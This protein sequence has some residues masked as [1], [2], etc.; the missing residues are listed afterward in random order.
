MASRGSVH[1]IQQGGFDMVQKTFHF[2]DLDELQSIIMEI[3]RDEDYIHASG[4]LFQLYNPRLDIEEKRMVSMLT[5]AFSNACL[6][7]ITSGNIAGEKLD[8][9][10]LPVELS[11]TCFRETTLIQYDLNMAKTTPFEAG[12]YMNHILEVLSDLKCLQV[13]YAS[14]SNS[15]CT[16][17]REIRHHYV[18]KFGVKAGRSILKKNTAHVYGT[19][20]YDS[21][22]VV[23]A[24]VSKALKIYMD[25]NLGWTPIGIDMTIT[26]T[27]GD[28]V[29][30]EIDKRPATEIYSKYLKVEP[31]EYFVQNVCEFPLI[32]K[33]NQVR[34]ARVPVACD[35]DGA[36][37]FTS[38]IHKG[39]HF[40]LAYADRNKMMALSQRSAEELKEFRPEAVYIF[41]CS[42]R[43]RV[44]GA[45]YLSERSIYRKYYPNL[46][47]V[48]GNAE[49]FVAQNGQGG[50]LNSS[51]IAIGLKENAEAVDKVVACRTADDLEAMIDSNGEI[52][53]IE[54]I[55]TFLESTSQELN[56]T[57]KK[58]GKIAY[59]DQLTKIY[60]RWELEKKIS[61][62]LDLSD[63]KHKYGLIFLDIDHFK[64][65]NDTYGHDVGDMAL[66][67]VAN[68][69][70]EFVKEG[71]AFGR[72][73]G[74]EFIYVVPDVDEKKLFDFAER[75]R[76]SVEE[77]CFVGVKHLTI[78]VGATVAKKEDTP[79]SLVKRADTAVYEA[80]ERGRNKV[81]LQ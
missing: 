17:M 22:I 8:L 72:W 15:I 9:S 47:N 53:F 58:L 60:N 75:L 21:A 49:L 37:H 48:T 1:S 68:I 41:E 2:S 71:H 34:I 63:K 11:M 79:E 69:V 73:G 52:P 10:E 26:G 32:L 6:A 57:N 7:G 25:N 3:N 65:V 30:T 78:S 61:E 74:E 27:L 39:D 50:D 38:D 62:A 12:R 31:N 16:F 64:D 44:L 42:N 70:K 80:K 20:V 19:E 59:T 33:R 14:H 35:E 77:T 24:F 29:V 76:K 54:R 18:P 56:S 28:T 55:L 51:L 13:F 5:G 81:V 23:V 43:V 40:R 4:V 46:S 66:L 36:I 45:D 67:G